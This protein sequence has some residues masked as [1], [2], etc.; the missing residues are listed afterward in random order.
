VLTGDLL[1]NI[2]LRVLVP[3][4]G[5]VQKLLTER[6]VEQEKPIHT[7]HEVVYTPQPQAS[8]PQES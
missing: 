6:I 5:D 7:T 3:K 4:G 8:P 1:L 2:R